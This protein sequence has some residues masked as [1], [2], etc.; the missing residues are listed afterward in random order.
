LQAVDNPLDQ[1]TISSVT[2]TSRE[3]RRQK[4]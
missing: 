3:Y 1:L 4:K 2:E